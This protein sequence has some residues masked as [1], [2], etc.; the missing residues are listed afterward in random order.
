VKSVISNFLHGPASAPEQASFPPPQ[1]APPSPVSQEVAKTVFRK[2]TKDGPYSLQLGSY[3][4]MES[5]LLHLPRFTNLKQPLFWNR[6][7]GEPE[8][9]MLF[10]GRFESFD[11]AGQYAN[12]NQLAGSPV[13]FR[14]YVATAGPLTDPE[15]LRQASLAVGLHGQEAAFEHELVN[16]VEIQIALERSREDALERCAEAEKKGLSCAVTQYE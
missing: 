16:G 6:D 4:T 10:A 2:R 3:P 1:I 15:Q 11:V 9:F 7:R 8:R 12:Q 5:M 14:P 13:V